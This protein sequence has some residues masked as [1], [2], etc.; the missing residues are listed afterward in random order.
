MP[1]SFAL[2]FGGSIFDFGRAA[3]NPGDYYLCWAHSYHP[4]GAVAGTLSTLDENN[5]DNR[6][7]STLSQ[8]ATYTY[9]LANGYSCDLL[10]WGHTR[11]Y[12]K[13]F[14]RST[15]GSAT[16][17]VSGLDPGASYVFRVY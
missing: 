7:V 13:G 4:G 10:G 1:S 16:A 6:G 11:S 2:G 17:T 12:A 3:L 5:F 14:V 9:T 15:A 8:Y